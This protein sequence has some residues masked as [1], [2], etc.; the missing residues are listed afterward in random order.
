MD[1]VEM[2]VYAHKLLGELTHH[3]GRHRAIGMGELYEKIF[4]ET[5]QNR[6]NDT[7]RLRIVITELRRQGVAIC[8]ESS[9]AGGGYYLASAGSELKDYL[10]RLRRRALKVLSLEAKMRKMTLAELLGQ[11]ELNLRG[12]QDETS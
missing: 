7:R 3:I 6:I 4:E 10:S 8:S 5:W 11:I 9:R 12:G 2:A 1:R